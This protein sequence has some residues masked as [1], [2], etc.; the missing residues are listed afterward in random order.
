M[1]TDRQEKSNRRFLLFMPTR[2]KKQWQ[3]SYISS[4]LHIFLPNV[5]G[6]NLAEDERG[7]L[8]TVE[9]ILRTSKNFPKS[10]GLTF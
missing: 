7:E 9:R 3:H 6:K 10:R 8:M 2:P 5:V 1:Q 4:L